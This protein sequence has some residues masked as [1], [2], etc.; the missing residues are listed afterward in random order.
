[1]VIQAGAE[2]GQAQV[3]LDAIIEVIVEV[4]VE[5]VNSSS[6]LFWQWVGGEINGIVQLGPPH[7]LLLSLFSALADLILMKL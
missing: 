2:L 4:G 1:M 7:K 6:L 3:K 5:V